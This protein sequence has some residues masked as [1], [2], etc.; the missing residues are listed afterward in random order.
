[1]VNALY[2][3]IKLQNHYHEG[4]EVSRRKPELGLQIPTL[5]PVEYR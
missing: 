3:R 5:R 4:H 1:V 2:V